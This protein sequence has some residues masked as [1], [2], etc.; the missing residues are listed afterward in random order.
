MYEIV[1]D[2]EQFKGKRLLQQHRLVNEVGSR[3]SNIK[4]SPGHSSFHS[5]GGHTHFCKKKGQSAKG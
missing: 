1:I 3:Y 5:L 4:S 2:S